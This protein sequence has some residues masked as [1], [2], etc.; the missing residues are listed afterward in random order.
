MD[1]VVRGFTDADGLHWSARQFEPRSD[2]LTGAIPGSF[3]VADLLTRAWLTFECQESS[4]LRRLA[5]APADWATCDEARLRDYLAEA[6]QV[7]RRPMTGP[8]L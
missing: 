2:V 6:R 8:L 1:P 3:G 5:P 7:R 4:D